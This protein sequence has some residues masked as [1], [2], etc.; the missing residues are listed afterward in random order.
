MKM[1][2][3]RKQMGKG[4]ALIEV[5]VY[6]TAKVGRCAI[7]GTNVKLQLIDVGLAGTVLCIM[8]T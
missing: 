7:L 4:L 2:F 8:T 6:L 5:N 3:V 1:L